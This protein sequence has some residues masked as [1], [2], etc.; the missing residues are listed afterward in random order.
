MTSTHGGK[1]KGAG[2]KPLTAGAPLCHVRPKV[3]LS[4]DL[5]QWVH[6]QCKAK[7]ISWPEYVRRLI[8]EDIG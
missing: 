1:R 3:S 8:I 5:D 4:A 2:R 6:L 7:G